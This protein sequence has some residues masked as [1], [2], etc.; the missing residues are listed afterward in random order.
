MQTMQSKSPLTKNTFVKNIKSLYQFT[1]EN[2]KNQTVLT[3]AHYR[4]VYILHYT[5]KFAVS[6][7]S[8]S[9]ENSLRI[10]GYTKYNWPYLPISKMF[11]SFKVSK[12]ARSRNMEL[13]SKVITFKVT[14]KNTKHNLVRSLTMTECFTLLSK[15][16]SRYLGTGIWKKTG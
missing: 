11:K 1:V 12:M 4:R 2:Y 16:G 10:C 7:Q 9:P 5:K 8:T 13:N 6:N 3:F 14:P 15:L